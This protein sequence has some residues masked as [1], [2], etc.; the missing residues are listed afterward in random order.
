MKAEMEAGKLLM[1]LRSR[2]A[3]NIYISSSED[4]GEN[5]TV[6]VRT[7]LP[8]NNSSISAIRLQSGG[9]AVVYNEVRF[10]DN[11]EKTVW[12]HQRCPVTVAISDD[13]GK[14]WP[15]KRII[16][17]GEG[18][19]GR[20]NDINNRRYEYPVMMQGEDGKIHVAYS[21]GTRKCVKY[22]CIDEPW[23]R[24]EKMLPGAEGDPNMPCQR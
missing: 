14:T 6:P 13:W 7:E 3:D 4:Y 2:F 19:V 11:T 23:I 1:L 18:F 17:N 5:W 9:L 10:N 24:G 15:Y 12:P 8:N 21:Y 22:V 16:E 20:Y